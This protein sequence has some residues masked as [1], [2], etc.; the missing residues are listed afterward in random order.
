MTDQEQKK[1][2]ARL[3]AA[4]KGAVALTEELRRAAGIPDWCG[5]DSQGNPR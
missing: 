3:R 5:L 1:R 4:I 2:H